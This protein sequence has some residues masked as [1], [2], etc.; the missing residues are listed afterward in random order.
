MIMI[1]TAIA[2]TKLLWLLLL[3]RLKSASNRIRNARNF[4][5]PV[6]RCSKK[7]F[8]NSVCT[9]QVESAK[10]SFKIII[11]RN[12]ISRKSL[13]KISELFEFECCVASLQ[14]LKI[15]TFRAYRQCHN[16]GIWARSHI[17]NLN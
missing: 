1:I 15:Y 11:G 9:N 12:T 14:C 10:I 6:G 5:S 17:P 16:I 2:H 7:S 4:C 3:L 13:K 8:F